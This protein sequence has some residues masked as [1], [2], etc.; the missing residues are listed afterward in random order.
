[1]EINMTKISVVLILFWTL[2][3]TGGILYT[4]TVEQETYCIANNELY[5]CDR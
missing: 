5:V 4:G 2:L 3:I 1:M